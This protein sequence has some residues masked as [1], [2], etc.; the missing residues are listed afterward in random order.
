MNKNLHHIDRYFKEGIEG[1]Q[2]E[3]DDKIWA[4]LE[5]Q[6]DKRDLFLAQYKYR[7]L[8]NAVAAILLVGIATAAGVYFYPIQ[9]N[10]TPAQ[11]VAKQSRSIQK[12][13]ASNQPEALVSLE[14]TIVPSTIITT[15]E[16]NS[17]PTR[18]NS[19]TKKLQSSL[20]I[21]K[22]QQNNI[23]LNAKTQQVLSD[24]PISV[25]TTTHTSTQPVKESINIISNTNSTASAQLKAQ[26]QRLPVEVIKENQQTNLSKGVI[27]TLA[28]THEPLK[29]EEVRF[30]QRPTEKLQLPRATSAVA[31]ITAFPVASTLSI[32]V[33]PYPQKIVGSRNNRFFLSTLVMPEIAMNAIQEGRREHHEDDR[34]KI[35]EGEKVNSSLLYGVHVGFQLSKKIAIFSGYTQSTTQSTV[36][37][38][39]IYARPR[40]ERPGQPTSTDNSFKLNCAAGYAYVTSKTAI[41]LPAFGDSL[42][43]LPSSTTIKYTVIPLGIKYNLGVGKFSIN[44]VIGLNLHL[45]SSASLNANFIEPTGTKSTETVSIQGVKKSYFSGLLG[46]SMD[47]R[48]T[49]NLRCFVFPTST[50]GISTINQNTPA[51]TR[52]NSLGLQTGIAISF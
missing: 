26:L 6:L 9:K 40:R 33:T 7:I 29:V 50:V 3:P 36:T 43:G 1:H 39:E 31:S 4:S 8:R 17:S 49:S 24:N 18:S 15:L 13:L 23:Q 27:S 44:P 41:A 51:S 21:A 35:A 10:G 34:A 52:R 22:N 30:I 14:H 46:V 11:A 38:Q 25:V 16:K 42:K 12:T 37:Q 20:V 48:L 2:E 45:L 5:S 19:T 28:N 47:Y 32:A